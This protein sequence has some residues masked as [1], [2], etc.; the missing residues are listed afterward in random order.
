MM[1]FLTAVV[2]SRTAES[3]SNQTV[4]TNNAAY[5]ADDLDAYD[6][7]CDEINSAKIALM[8][9]LSHYGFDN[10]AEDGVTRL[11]KYS[12]LS[13]AEAIQA[14]CDVKATNIILQTLP[15]EIYALVNTKFLN[16]LPLEWITDTSS[17]VNHNAYMGSSSA[18]QIDYAPMVQH[19][20]EYS[21][22]ETR[23]VVSVYQKRDD[24]IDAINHMMSF[25]TV[26]V[27]SRQNFVSA[28]SSR[29][30]TSGSGGAPGKQR[31]IMCYNYKGEGYMS[32]QCTKPKRKR[33]AEW[34][35]DK[36][37]P[38]LYDGRIIEK[39]DAVVIPDTEETLMLAEESRS[40]MIKKQ[41]DPQMTEKKIELSIEQ[42]FW[43][44]YSVQTDEPDL[45]ATTTIV[46][47]PKELSKVSMV[48]SCLKKLKS[49]LASFDMVVKER[50]T[51]TTITEDTWGFEH[52]KACFHDDIIR[53]VKALKELFTSFDQCLIDEVTEVQNVFK[54][55]KLAVE[56]HREEKNKFLNKMENVLN[57]LSSS[58]S[59]PTFAEF[60]E[61]NELKAQAQAKD[62]VILQL[63][64]K[65]RSLKEQCD[66]LINKVTLK[67]AEVSDLNSSLQEKVLV[68][69]TLKEQLNKLKGKAVLTEAVSLNPINPELLKIDV[70]LIVPK[71]RKNRTAHT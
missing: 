55:M 22:P 10:L 47:V 57:T 51:T 18:P 66:D 48:N 43:S 45:S 17:L 54:Q 70:A 27:T 23:F 2:T 30:F 13:A 21:P 56:Q 9:N 52:T 8:A 65:L 61:I 64:E 25:L 24:P 19:S 4:I 71:L 31:V 62:I 68:I 35:K 3:S 20:S 40:K 32:K 7:D 41:N 38:K 5:Q 58:E 49:Y 1:S 60:F 36:L 34:F 53:F 50:T 63:K 16:T 39:S 29:Q 67:S 28:G 37:K 46:E 69:T 12:E 11:K 6:S 14:D 26:V 42:A 59:A 44:Q 15:S 33:D